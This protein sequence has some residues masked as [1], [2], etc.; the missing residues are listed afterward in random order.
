MN[1]R[2]SALAEKLKEQYPLVQIFSANRIYCCRPLLFGAGEI[3]G[4]C[5]ASGYVSQWM[6]GNFR[7]ALAAFELWDGR[8]EPRGWER[9]R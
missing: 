4:P 6:Y 3:V 5:D 2:A 9:R 8:G 7:D 1:A